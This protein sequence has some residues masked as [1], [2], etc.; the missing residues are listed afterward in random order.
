MACITLVIAY[1]C[2][3][4]V[5][6]SFITQCLRLSH[7]PAVGSCI[8]PRRSPGVITDGDT[9]QMLL[10][11]M[12]LDRF[13]SLHLPALRRQWFG[14]VC[15]GLFMVRP[16]PLCPELRPRPSSCTQSST[17]SMAIDASGGAFWQCMHVAG[18]LMPDQLPTHRSVRLRKSVCAKVANLV[19]GEQAINIALNNLSLV[20]IS[21]SLNQVIRCALI[22]GWILHCFIM[23]PCTVSAWLRLASDRHASRQAVYRLQSVHCML[24]APCIMSG[25]LKC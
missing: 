8:G 2:C 6:L 16:T 15:I 22:P 24:L 12:M 21:L 25:G 5:P 20:L 23:S 10:P 3:L 18:R 11:V 14:L 19:V 1:H 7:H 13:R 17:S 4:G 9:T